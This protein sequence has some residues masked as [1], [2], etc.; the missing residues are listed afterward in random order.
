EKKLVTILELAMEMYARGYGFLPVDIYESDARKF[1]V[2]GNKLLLPFA[3][4]P[5][6]G[7]AAA[8]GVVGAR[9]DGPFISVEDFQVRTHLNKSAMELLRQENCFADLPEKSQMSLFA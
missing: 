4:L 5:N 2:K 6:I 8:Q 7:E 3:A 1:M 9:A